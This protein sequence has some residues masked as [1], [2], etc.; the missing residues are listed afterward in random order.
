MFNRL[1]SKALSLNIAG[2]TV[3]FSTQ[4]DFEFCLAGRVDVPSAKMAS[5]VKLSRDDLKREAKSIKAVEKQFV[6]IVSRAIEEPGS[7][8]RQ[9]RQIDQHVFSQDHN[10][11]EIMGALKEKGEEY[12]ELKKVALV[13]YM[14][15]LASRQEVIKQIYYD[16]KQSARDTETSAVEQDGGPANA[17][18]ETVILDSTLAEPLIR[19]ASAVAR[20]PKGEAVVVPIKAGQV[21]DL[22][23][24]K[25][26]Y[27]L[28]ADSELRL[29]D[30]AGNAHTLQEGKNILGRD[31]VCNVVIDPS[32]RDVSRLHLIVERLGE[33]S[34]RLTDL[35]SHG[36]F[37][38]ARFLEKSLD[39]A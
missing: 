3:S 24:S 37:V 26:N 15:Y 9:L 22:M 1:F 12:D 29:V 13:K 21:I 38:P 10:W 8:S 31:T 34:V 20:L 4:N 39:L 5:L 23:L 14:Q 36:T 27:K 25:H 32:F 16:R 7:V 2:Q 11:R 17:M 35:S 6:D 19:K 28:V 33:S 30:E 18:R